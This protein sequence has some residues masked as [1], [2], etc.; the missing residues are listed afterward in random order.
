MIFNRT[1]VHEKMLLE[2]VKYSEQRYGYNA[3]VKAE[4]VEALKRRR[5]DSTCNDSGNVVQK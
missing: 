1:E 2:R 3:K 5:T 4:F